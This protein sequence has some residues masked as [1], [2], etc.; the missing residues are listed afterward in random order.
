MK[1][2]PAPRPRLGRNGTYNPKNYTKY[3]KDFLTEAKKQCKTYYE[4]AI[5]LEAIFF[6]EIP[7]STSKKKREQ[8]IGEYHIKRPDADNLLKTI[9]DS[10]NGTFYKDDSQVCEVKMMKIYSDVP[11]VQVNLYEI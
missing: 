11:R 8:L 4:G 10:L 5:R 7:A 6:M 1:P 2:F 3:K 9:K